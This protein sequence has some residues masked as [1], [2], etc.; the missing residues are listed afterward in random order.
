MSVKETNVYERTVV[1]N[2][3]IK[4]PISVAYD[5]VS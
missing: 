1:L 2:G 5:A 3:I 4:I